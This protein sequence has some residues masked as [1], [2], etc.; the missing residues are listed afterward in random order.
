MVT[1][2]RGVQDGNS[3]GPDEGALRQFSHRKLTLQA[4]TAPQWIWWESKSAQSICEVSKCSS[5]KQ[6]NGI[7]CF[8]F[9]MHLL[10][11]E[12]SVADFKYTLNHEFGGKYWPAA[13]LQGSELIICDSRSNLSLSE[14]S[15]VLSSGNPLFQYNY[16]NK[17]L[18]IIKSRG[19]LLGQTQFSGSS[20]K[21]IVDQTVDFSQIKNPFQIK[22][23]E[24]VENSGEWLSLAVVKYFVCETIKFRA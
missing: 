6:P 22:S 21:F 2:L 24:S 8:S 20:E 19:N 5:F 16:L 9:A 11:N 4:N 7:S 18:E 17:A 1:Q 15:H 23:L 14:S 10:L 12:F 13:G 3:L